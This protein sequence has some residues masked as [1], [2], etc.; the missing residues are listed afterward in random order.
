MSELGIMTGDVNLSTPVHSKKMATAKFL[1]IL[2]GEGM[3][4]KFISDF[5]SFQDYDHSFYFIS[6][7]IGDHIAHHAKYLKAS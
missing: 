4:G 6:T 7:F 5:L 2:C 1:D 3:S